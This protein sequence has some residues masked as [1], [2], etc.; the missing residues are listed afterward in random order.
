M[1]RFFSFLHLKKIR[2]RQFRHFVK[3]YPIILALPLPMINQM[4]HSGQEGENEGQHEYP[5]PAVNILHPVQQQN[6]QQNQQH[7]QQPIDANVIVPQQPIDENALAPSYQWKYGFF[8]ITA[9]GSMLLASM[10]YQKYKQNNE[11]S[12]EEHKMLQLI[13][14]QRNTA[15]ILVLGR[16][17]VGK[18]YLINSLMEQ[19]IAT[20]KTTEIQSYNVDITI[21]NYTVARLKIWDSSG[22]YGDLSDKQCVQQLKVAKDCGTILLVLDGNTPRLN[23]D[24]ERLCPI[25]NRLYNGKSWINKTIIVATRGNQVIDLNSK[26]YLNQ[27]MTEWKELISS[28]LMKVGLSENE[29]NSIPIVWSFNRNENEWKQKLIVTIIERAET[30]QKD[31]LSMIGANNKQ[32]DT[33]FGLGFKLPSSSSIVVT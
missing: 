1:A 20:D 27:R 23:D 8:A 2:G 24:L 3:L 14:K 10:L 18:S 25:L 13:S 6:Q 9:I 7:N 16:S 5:S 4:I 32:H 29:A 28:K 19:N 33:I 30:Q 31:A 26:Q 12:D 22:F 21:Q 11:L 15:E 17:G